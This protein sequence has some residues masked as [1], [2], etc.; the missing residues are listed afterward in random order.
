MRLIYHVGCSAF[1]SL[2]NSCIFLI[3]SPKNIDY[4][5]LY[6][7]KFGQRFSKDTSMDW[8][9]FILDRKMLYKLKEIIQNN[10]VPQ[11]VC[12]YIVKSEKK[13]NDAIL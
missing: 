7:D 10:L 5:A 2:E 9:K 4:G 1:I 12:S 11:E 8:N 13:I 6:V 3:N